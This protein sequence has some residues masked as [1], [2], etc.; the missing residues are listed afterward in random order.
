MISSRP[1]L[2]RL[3]AAAFV[4]ASIG[5]AGGPGTGGSAVAAGPPDSDWLG[6]VNVY[7][8]QSGLAPVTEEQSWSIGGRNH[9]CWMLL[10]G[11][12]HDEPTGTPGY[13]TDGDAAGN[14]GNVAVS[15]DPAATARRHIDLW[16]TGPFHAIGVLRPSLKR[17]GFGLCASPPAKSTTAWKS[18]ATLDVI[19]GIDHRVPDRATPVLFPGNGATTS[20]TRFIAESPDPRTFCGWSGRTVGLP[21]IA[22]M[23]AGVSSANASLSGPNGPIQTC[24]LHAGNTSGLARDILRGDDAVVVVPAAPLK[25]GTYRA[26]VRSTG[27]NADWSFTVD[28]NAPL[29]VTEPAPGISRPL[30]AGAGFQPVTPFRFADSRLGHRLQTL[31]GGKEVRIKVAGTPGIPTTATAVSANF[32][33]TG[34]RG[35]GFLTAYNCLGGV[36]AVSTLNYFAGSSV[37]NQS[38]VPLDR[39]DLCLFSLRDAEVVID[40]NGFVAP[41]GTEIFNPVKPARLL[42]SRKST[43]LRAFTRRTVRVTGGASPAPAGATAV[44]INLVGV[45]PTTNGWIRAFP[46]HLPEPNVSSVS[47]RAGLVTSTSVIVPTSPDGT[48][49]LTSMMPTDVVIDITGWFGSGSGLDFVPVDPIRLA[50]TRS[51][52]AQLNPRRDGQALRAGQVLEVPV[53]GVRGVPSNTTAV[54][55][56][57]VALGS[58][59]PGW[60]RVVPCGS[61]SN[62]STLNFSSSS[63]VANGSNVQLSS[64]GSV[65]VVGMTTSHVI[66]DIT[67]I[68]S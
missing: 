42:D 14:N 35:S 64:K 22:M 48:I 25:A 24:V 31:R 2:R 36:P 46:C 63:P 65:C 67:G 5:I 49:C 47:A 32:V 41:S 56:N 59:S 10:N 3:F 37:S 28:P 1:A 45:K 9:S 54:S 55:L 53:A 40:V 4:L 57:L 21:L 26:S 27:G 13:T 38:I 44:A 62:I 18:A 19:R 51:F 39:G 68:W 15:S 8:A 60:L 6:I 58:R 34:A 11:I 7:R 29:T 23:P 61:S 33:V 30:A 16:M 17:S 12:A 52:L 20:L 66:V 43:P 50:D